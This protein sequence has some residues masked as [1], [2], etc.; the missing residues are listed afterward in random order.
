MSDDDDFEGK[1]ITNPDENS[2]EAAES[3]QPYVASMR[4][5]VWMLIGAHPDGLACWEVE[6]ITGGLHQTVSAT[7]TW[8]YHW[9]WLYRMGKNLTPSNRKAHIYHAKRGRMPHDE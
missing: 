5:R 4:R 9:G 8:L 2:Q 6:Q 1:V 3:V 7:I